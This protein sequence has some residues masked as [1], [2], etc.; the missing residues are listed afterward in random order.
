MLPSF[1]VIWT[2]PSSV[3]TQMIPGR[4]GDSEM[5]MIVQ[6]VSAPVT[7]EVMPPVGLSVPP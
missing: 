1:R 4:L 2:S 6:W 3:P 5:V 7:S